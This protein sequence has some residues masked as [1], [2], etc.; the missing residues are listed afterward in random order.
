[1]RN[2]VIIDTEYYRIIVIADKM[3]FIAIECMWKCAANKWSR[4]NIKKLGEMTD[5]TRAKWLI[6]SFNLLRLLLNAISMAFI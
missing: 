3:E 5:V 4:V 6:G 2:D 1:M